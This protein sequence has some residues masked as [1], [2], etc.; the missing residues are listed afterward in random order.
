MAPSR[1]ER[2]R[3]EREAARR[4]PNQAQ[5]A[6]YLDNIQAN[7]NQLGDWTTQAQ[8]PMA[9]FDAMS[10]EVVMQKAALLDREAMW[11]LGFWLV[12]DMGG[13]EGSEQADVGLELR[14]APFRSLTRL[15][16]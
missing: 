3:A 10:T 9:M 8:D 6:A 14:T 15:E 16:D 1:Q 13:V 4:T 7:V 12:N 11:S 2:R 5:R